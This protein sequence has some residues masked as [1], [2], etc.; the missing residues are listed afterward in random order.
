MLQ[1]TR[2]AFARGLEKLLHTHD[3]PQ[4]TAVAFAIGVF[5]G[6]SPV[7]GLHTVLAV[8]IAFAFNLNRVAILIGVYVNLPWFIGPYYTLATLFGAAILRTP[9][10][11]GLLR[12]F[13][14]LL[15]Q[16]TLDDLH[17][18][19]DLLRPLFW[20]YVLGSTILAALAAVLAYRAALAFVLA[21]RRWHAGSGHHR[22]A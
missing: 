19:F 21:R 18:L 17:R 2:A 11:P 22:Q 13:V 14:R 5:L 12:D 7:L 4:R 3:T 6:F 15:D 20:A 9:P 16:W 1:F 10:P 8:A